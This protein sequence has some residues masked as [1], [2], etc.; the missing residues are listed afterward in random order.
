MNDSI[1]IYGNGYLMLCWNKRK[2]V[3]GDQPYDLMLSSD[4]A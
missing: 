3:Y 4:T 2:R 1:R